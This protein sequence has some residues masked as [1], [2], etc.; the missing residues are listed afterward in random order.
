M[1]KKGLS[2]VA[3]LVLGMQKILDSDLSTSCSRLS[4]GQWSERLPP[5]PLESRYQSQETIVMT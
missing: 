1:E 3:E 4:S 2:S 5:E